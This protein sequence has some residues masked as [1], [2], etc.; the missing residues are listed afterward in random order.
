[1]TDTP[2]EDDKSPGRPAPEDGS[3]AA[4]LLGD[5]LSPVVAPEYTDEERLSEPDK[6]EPDKSQ[7]DKDGTEEAGDK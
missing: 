2:L 4:G 6:S 1:M 7:P 5:A 3:E